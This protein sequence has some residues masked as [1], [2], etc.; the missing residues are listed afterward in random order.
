MYIRAGDGTIWDNAVLELK[1]VLQPSS[2]TCELE[3]W[4]HTIDEH[5]LSVYLIEGDDSISIWQEHDASGDQW[6]RVIL[7]IGRIA[8]PWSIQFIVEKGWGNG[9]ISIDDVSLVGCEFPPIRP[10]CT[11]DQFRCNRGACIPKDRL[12]DFT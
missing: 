2:A 10:N 4:H 8:K 12:C 7:P 6:M 3:F 9:A 5:F 11:D 1:Q